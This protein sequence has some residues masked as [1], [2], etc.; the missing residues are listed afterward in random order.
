MKTCSCPP[1]PRVTSLGFLAVSPV[2]MVLCLD[3]DVETVYNLP[4]RRRSPVSGRRGHGGRVGNPR[5]GMCA[6]QRI[7]V[8]R[9]R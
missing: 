2:R 8:G 4:G 3:R 9:P 5:Y 7:V 6:G 1:A